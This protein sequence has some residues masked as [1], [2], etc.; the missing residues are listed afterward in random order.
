M[1]SFLKS[2]I[3]LHDTYD[4]KNTLLVLPSKRSV[5]FLKRE[6]AKQKDIIWLPEIIDIIELIERLSKLQIIDNQETLL[7]FYQIYY[8]LNL[9]QEPED[10]TKF[11]SW[12]TPLLS[13]FNEIDRFLVDAEPFFKYHKELKELSYFGEKKTDF[14]KSY[15]KFWEDMPKLYSA[16]KTELLNE[17]IAYQ[18]LAYRIA[19]ENLNTYLE[20]NSKQHLFIGFNALNK[21]EELIIEAFLKSNKGKV[22]WDI[23]HHYLEEFKHPSQTFISNYQKKW[24]DYKD[25][26]ILVKDKNYEKPKKIHFQASVKTVGQCKS[27][28]KILDGFN[29][30]EINNTAIILNDEHLLTP[31]LNSI[32]KHVENLN[33]TMG[34]SLKDSPL[35]DFF[36]ILISH[37]KL[38]KESISKETLLKLCSHAMIQ[39]QDKTINTIKTENT[40]YL[41][42][43]EIKQ[44]A[45]EK[46]IP[47]L[48]CLEIYAEPLD[49][50][51]AILHFMDDLQFQI[52]ETLAPFLKAY[53]HVFNQLKT[54]AAQNPILKILDVCTL[55]YEL[56]KNEKLSFKGSQTKGLQIMGMLETR[57]LDFKNVILMSV[58]EGVIPTGKTDNS[59]ITY[60]QKK[61]YDL[62]THKDK[63][64]IYAYHFFRLIQ[65]AENCYIVYD[66][67]QSGLNKGELSRFAKY[68]EIFKI[69]EH[70]YFYDSFSLPTKPISRD[71]LVIEKTDAVL[72][73]LNTL[74]KSGFSPTALTTYIDNPIKFYKQ[75]IL[76]VKEEEQFEEEINHKVFGIVVHNTLEDLY[77]NA[78]STLTEESINK[79]ITQKEDLIKKHFD[80]NYSKEAYLTGSNRLKY[81]IALA[82]V[83]EFLNQ[84]LKFLS[85]ND[86]KIL[87]VEKDISAS[88]QI[89]DQDVVIKGKID[90]ID[91]HNDT[92]RI[93][94]YKTG[95]VT[96]T[97]LNIKEWEDIISNYKFSKVFQTLFY[98]LVYSKSY[99]ISNLQAGII[100]MKNLQKWFMPVKKGKVSNIDASV[101]EQFQEYLGQLIEEILDPEMPFVEKESIFES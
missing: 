81:E 16:L 99:T 83:T 74:S 63:D 91:I 5:S 7:F 31:I 82:S 20:D 18:G 26:I 67:D 15:I 28:S 22:I 61:Q 37:Q 9:N 79:F 46:E 32:P 12:A 27:L 70:E 6:F 97:D 95:Y 24:K 19:F 71:P 96:T 90:R 38:K 66:N 59:Y 33:I 11:S 3:Q 54:M 25:N 13:D 64:A 62:P 14:I 89:N 35:S 44:I 34:L 55:F 10:Y 23:D 88:I 36:D 93:I 50:L 76:N 40:S 51:N 69:P 65:R 57:L 48:E 52:I 60:S 68:L 47:F 53:Q 1:Q 86:I 30:E 72:E 2:Y 42:L 56:E 84:E 92:L 73:K 58:N 4:N 39:L 77:R 21:A 87:A 43:T 100:S 80:D 8:N 17:K 94:D 45:S 98:A 75:Y 41:S 49:F 101:L 78:D 29:E 85:N